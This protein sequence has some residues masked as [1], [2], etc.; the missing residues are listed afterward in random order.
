MLNP[1]RTALRHTLSA[2]RNQETERKRRDLSCKNLHQ[3]IQAVRMGYLSQIASQKA[4]HRREFVDNPENVWK[5]NKYTHMN[6]GS[7][8]VPTLQ[9]PRGLVD[10]DKEKAAV[11]LQAFFPPQPESE[12]RSPDREETLVPAQPYKRITEAEVRTA[13]FRS[14]PKKAPGPDNIPFLIWQKV[15]EEAKGSIMALYRASLRLSHLPNGWRTARVVPL[16]KL[17]KPD[18]TIPK[19]F[20]SISPLATISKGLEAVVANRLSFM[21]EK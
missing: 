17:G 9:G 15:W 10:Q 21:A 5:A 16:R 20:R 19:A 1:I 11:L 2:L 4:V 7:R 3:Q 18:Y 14:N 6:P 12:D 8:G 13:T